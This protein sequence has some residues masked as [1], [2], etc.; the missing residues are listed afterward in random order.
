MVEGPCQG[1]S[2]QGRL[3]RG[4][5]PIVGG[6]GL[7]K[8]LPGRVSSEQ[9]PSQWRGRSHPLPGKTQS[10][11]CS[12]AALPGEMQLNSHG[13]LRNRSSQPPGSLQGCIAGVWRSCFDPQAEHSAGGWAALRQF[14][15][16]AHMQLPANVCCGVS[17]CLVFVLPVC[18]HQQQ[19]LSM[20]LQA[21]CCSLS[22]AACCHIKC[23][24]YLLVSGFKH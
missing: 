14:L 7:H 8:A 5:V 18:M 11:S 1:E 21:K 16:S 20:Y 12:A 6:V 3:L 19:V 10:I 9:A 24:F 22:G 13:W 4:L 17:L 15:G 23:V 2:F